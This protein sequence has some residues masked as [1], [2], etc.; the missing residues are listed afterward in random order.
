MKS[1]YLLCC[2]VLAAA[3]MP[4]ATL[5]IS[6]NAQGSN[7]NNTE[8]ASSSGNVSGRIRNCDQIEAKIQTR[9]QQYSNNKKDYSAAYQNMLD[10]L[11]RFVANIKAKGYD[12]TN[13]EA[14]IAILKQKIDEF[15]QL[16][17]SSYAQ[18]QQTQQY[19]CGQAQGTFLQSLLQS[20]QQIRLA[21]QKAQE[22]RTFY[23]TVI[24]PDLLELRESTPGV[25]S[26]SNTQT[27]D[28][29]QEN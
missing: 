8:A 16:T 12:T 10:R 1:K 29:S 21:H 23:T 2:M 24:K 5:A 9:L 15:N 17:T 6:S 22:I 7:S 27:S 3:L 28:S 26:N 25:V 13:L 20:R 4:T 19:T 11:N 18:L 14:D